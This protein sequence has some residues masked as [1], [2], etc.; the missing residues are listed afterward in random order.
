MCKNV[1]LFLI[2]MTV[3]FSVFSQTKKTKKQ[4][5]KSISKP[6]YTVKNLPPR[7]PTQPVKV[8][9]S[10][11]K[12]DSISPKLAPNAPKIT[13]PS[14]LV[15]GP[16]SEGPKSYSDNNTTIKTENKE[17]KPS[18]TIDKNLN[19]NQS[20]KENNPGRLSWLKNKI[21]IGFKSGINSASINKFSS[22]VYSG[23]N[24]PKAKSYAGFSGGLILNY[25]IYSNLYLQSEILL[26]QNGAQI[27][28][29]MNIFKYRINYLQFPLL[30]KMELGNKKLNYFVTAGPYFGY[31]I[32]KKSDREIGGKIITEKLEF[33]KNYTIFGEKDKRFDFGPA[34][35]A[36]IQYQIDKI[37]LTW[38]NRYQMG[39]SDPIKYKSEKPT[40]I[41]NTGRNRSFSS[42]I[43]INYPF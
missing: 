30:L 26:S 24:I 16:L 7:V 4:T 19:V 2:S 11:S 22:I 12:K 29:K 15:K 10:I 37:K 17:N 31:A 14:K 21:A 32:S 33:I 41:G 23:V 42:T 43:S 3:S 34:L 6:I 20:N 18:T 36:G 5:S 13:E 28:E 40:L 38:E 8:N 35:G 25:K 27:D 1:L 9:Q 39:L